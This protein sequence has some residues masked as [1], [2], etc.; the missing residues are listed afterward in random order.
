M[1]FKDIDDY[2]FLTKN[3]SEYAL[4][5]SQ[6]LDGGTPERLFNIRGILR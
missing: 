4:L 3:T 2:L 5:S 1:K 6:I